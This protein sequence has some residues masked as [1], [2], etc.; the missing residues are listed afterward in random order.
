MLLLLMPADRAGAAAAAKASPT[1]AES[2]EAASVRTF[3]V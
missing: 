2:V 1:A 3:M